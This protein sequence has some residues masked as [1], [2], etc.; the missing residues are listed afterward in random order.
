[1]PFHETAVFRF[2]PALELVLFDR[3]EAGIRTRLAEL[4]RD[5]AF[6]GVLLPT[7]RGPDRHDLARPATTR[8][9]E[10]ETALLLLTLRTPGPLPQY[11]RRLLAHDRGHAIA[12]LVLDGVLEIEVDGLFR[13]GPAAIDALAQDWPELG[14]PDQEGAPSAMARSVVAHLSMQALRH[15]ARL[16]IDDVAALGGRLYRYNRLPPTPPP[17]FIARGAE[18]RG[19][20]SSDLARLG[21]ADSRIAAALGRGW[22]STG[23]GASDG[24]MSWGPRAGV[25]SPGGV[26][27]TIKLYVSPLPPDVPATLAASLAAAVAHRALALKVGAGP[28]GLLRPDKLVI[29]FGRREQLQ[30]AASRLAGEL[31]GIPAHGVPFTAAVTDDGLLSWGADPPTH[32]GAGGLVGRAATES[33]RSWLT[34]QLA[35][36][37]IAGRGAAEPA[38]AERSAVRFALRRAAAL[39]V[40]PATWTPRDT[41]WDE[42]GGG[43]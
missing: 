12:N 14:G 4:S 36:A 26:R 9:V 5:P 28:Y 6:Y 18:G 41:M 1:M 32:D 42:G 33:W 20:G 8:P 38:T 3:L 39:Q 29:Y 11:A 25:D 35:A 40:D 21:L 19:P 16:P 17:L 7:D 27:G 30:A 22:V 37:I 34:T 23:S 43:S 10:R 31:A 13:S 15:A 2:N 24:W